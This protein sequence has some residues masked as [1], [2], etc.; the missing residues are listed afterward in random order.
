MEIY[1]TRIAGS[2]VNVIFTGKNYFFHSSYYGYLAIAERTEESYERIGTEDNTQEF[3]LRAGNEHTIG[4][5]MSDDVVKRA[6]EKFI[7][8]NENRYIPVTCK[9]DERHADLNACHVQISYTLG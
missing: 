9:F 6:A 7:R 8:K 1:K 5:S 4:G 2:E 3:I